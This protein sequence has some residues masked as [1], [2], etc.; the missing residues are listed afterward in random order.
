MKIE[1]K[2]GYLEHNKGDIS[3]TKST[4]ILYRFPQGWVGFN[5]SKKA[6]L[7]IHLDNG[8]LIYKFD[9]S[10]MVH[11]KLSIL[12]YGDNYQ[13]KDKPKLSLLKRMARKL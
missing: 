3:V 9:T 11:S 1:K 4:N 2:E 10:S 12:E 13:W 5:K 6:A 8:V 7:K